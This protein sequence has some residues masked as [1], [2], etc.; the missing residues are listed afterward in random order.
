MF[1]WIGGASGADVD[2]FFA[3][4]DAAG[5]RAWE[6]LA[7]LCDEVGSRPAGS[8]AYREAVEMTSGW[9]REDGASVKIE[10]VTVPVWIRGEERLDMIRPRS[11]RLPVLALGGSVGTTGVEGPVK[12]LS[13]FD[14]LGPEVAGHIVL[15]DVPMKTTEPAVEGYGEAVQYRV[16]GASRAAPF[17]AVAVLVRSVT[18]RSLSTPHTGG[19]WYQDGVRRIPAAAITPEDA[20]WIH[21]MVDRGTDV[22]LRL[23]LGSRDHGTA[24]DANV[25]GELRGRERPEEIVLLGAHLDSWDV[26]QGAHDDGA[27]VVEVVEALRL[28]AA[29]GQPRRTVRVVLFA[30]EEHGLSGGRAYANAHGREWHLMALESDLGGGRPLRFESS[31]TPEQVAWLG[32]LARGI[33]PVGGDGGGAD[34]GP[35]GAFGTLLVGL[36]PDDRH[37]FDV[38][39][40]EADTVDKVDPAA[41]G[42]AATRLAALAWRVAEYP[43]EA[44]RGPELSTR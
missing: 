31:G 37:Y 38:H 6:R 8:A 40:T 24:E 39:H 17:G 34:I 18:T 21:R 30:N 44:P 43:G 20:S 41:L 28:V 15:F 23:E 12:V 29:R 9:L 7:L 26:G 1:L 3:A 27:G 16:H 22:R 42:E 10:P 5:A 36:L 2:S 25:I 4:A 11:E 13:S 35:L 32:G 14:Q 19:T 33:L